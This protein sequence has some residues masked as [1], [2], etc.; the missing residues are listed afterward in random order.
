MTLMLP[1]VNF[2]ADRL[3]GIL[4]CCVLLQSTQTFT[5]Y[6][7]VLILTQSAISSF[8]WQ[9]FGSNFI[10]FILQNNCS[11]KCVVPKNAISVQVYLVSVKKKITL[12]SMHLKYGFQ[13]LHDIPFLEYCQDFQFSCQIIKL[14]QPTGI[15]LKMCHLHL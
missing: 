15:F 5:L 13:T 8:A 7:T 1:G 12:T 4:G 2:H 14:S 11:Y 9:L 10:Y 3:S 6:I